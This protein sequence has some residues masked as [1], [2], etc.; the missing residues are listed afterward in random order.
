MIVAELD[1]AFKMKLIFL[2]KSKPVCDPDDQVEDGVDKKVLPQK[3]P[4]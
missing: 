4:N 2:R 1:E 3:L